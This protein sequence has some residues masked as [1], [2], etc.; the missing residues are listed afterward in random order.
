[1][2]ILDA[3]QAGWSLGNK[4]S[5]DYYASKAQKAAID[6]YGP[7]AGDPGLFAA[8]GGIDAQQ[9]QMGIAANQETRDQTTFDT[10]MATTGA[11]HRWR[12]RPGAGVRSA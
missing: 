9:Q 11:G 12:C 4:M 7:M 6:K 10:N 8:L 3:V 2:T 5:Q 1:M